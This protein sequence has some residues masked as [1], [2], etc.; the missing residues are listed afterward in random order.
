MNGD[1]R[2]E[3]ENYLEGGYGIR[4][5]MEARQAGWAN[6]GRLAKVWQPLRLK[7]IQVSRELGT[8]F[9]SA[10]QVFDLRPAPRKFL[11]LNHTNHAASRFVTPGTILVTCSGSV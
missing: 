7:G 4:L 10:T 11:S 5:A 1:S 9:L 3:A 6:L 2:M 8:P